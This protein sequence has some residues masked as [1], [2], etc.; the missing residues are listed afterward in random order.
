MRQPVWIFD[1]DNTLHDA[2]AQIF[3]VMNR[4]MT[5]YIMRELGL[6]EN[7]ACQLRRHYWQVYGATL[8][9]LMLKHGV[10]GHHF[11][12]ET[13]AFDNFAEMVS[14]EKKLKHCLTQ[15]P[16]R[17]VVFTNGP[18]A[19]ANQ[20][21]TVMGIKACFEYVFSVESVQFHAKPSRRG[22]KTLLQRLSVRADQC[23]MVE[24]SLPALMTAK[25]L[26]MKTVFISQQLLKPI[27]VDY[28]LNSVLALTHIRV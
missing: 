24:D 25:R 28:R 4:A 19:Y 12:R 18:Q 8:K 20:V 9:G 23:V 10:D 26:G 5:H 11:L 21:L 6:S 17:K 7:A 1:L 13:H 16:G 14:F 22:F 2:S 3:P 27:F 15:L